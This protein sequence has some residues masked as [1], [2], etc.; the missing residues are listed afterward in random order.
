MGNR[1]HG[2][3]N[4]PAELRRFVLLARACKDKAY[5]LMQTDAELLGRTDGFPVVGGHFHYIRAPQLTADDGTGPRLILKLN[6]RNV[7]RRDAAGE[8]ARL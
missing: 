7:N 2:V 8:D 3:V 5:D 6:L 1:A 4:Y